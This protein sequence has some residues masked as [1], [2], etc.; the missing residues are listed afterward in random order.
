M[1]KYKIHQNISETHHKNFD[2]ECEN[3]NINNFRE[4][5]LLKSIVQNCSKESGKNQYEFINTNY[6]EIINKI[7][8]NILNKYDNVGGNDDDLIFGITPKV[9]S[10]IREA[11]L[12]YKFYLEPKNITEINN[13]LIIGG[14][15]GLEFCI[16]HYICGIVGVKI[17]NILGI[18]MPNVA[19]LQ[20]KYFELVGMDKICKSYGPEEFDKVPDYVYSNCCLAE[21]TCEVNFEY[22]NK[23]CSLSKGFYIVWGLWA[24][25]VPEYY[26]HYIVKGTHNE[27][28]NDGLVNKNTNEIIVK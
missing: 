15:Y 27:F 23:F 20:N 4:N 26:K 9:F 19:K 21:L 22:Y 13:L 1:K 12:F 8:F 3:I 24:A 5:P 16:I 14:G 28:I 6:K 11:I 7:D 25:D 17:K 2:K 10:Y 18:D